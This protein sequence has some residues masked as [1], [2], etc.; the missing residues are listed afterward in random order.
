M[1][2]LIVTLGTRDL[3]IYKSIIADENFDS[4][5]ETKIVKVKSTGDEVTLNQN[6]AEEGFYMVRSARYGGGKILNNFNVFKKH[7]RYPILKPALEMLTADNNNAVQLIFIYTDQENADERFRK[8]DTIEYAYILEKLIK[9][10]FPTINVDNFLVFKEVTDLDYQFNQFESYLNRRG[11]KNKVSLIDNDNINEI[12]L[13]AQ[14]G[15][16]QINTAITL[17]LIEHFPNLKLLQKKEGEGKTIESSF[18]L[19]YRLSLD[20]NIIKEFINENNYSAARKVILPLTKVDSQLRPIKNCLTFLNNRINFQHQQNIGLLEQVQIDLSA[21]YLRNYKEK[22]PHHSFLID[23]DIDK[24]NYFNTFEI[25]SICQLFLK[26]GNFALGTLTY[27]RLVEELCKSLIYE[28]FNIDL[29]NYHERLKLTLNENRL[30]GI[31][32]YLRYLEANCSSPSI[33]NIVVSII[34]TISHVNRDSTKGLNLL[35]NHVW[36]IHENKTIDKTIINGQCPNFLSTNGDG[37]FDQIMKALNMPEENIYDSMNNELK[38]KLD[39]I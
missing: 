29:D 22:Y 18:P 38:S 23:L 5:I 34:P 37:I 20:K 35:R 14:G 19:T 1:K 31:P 12:Y 36:L 11:D 24:T 30:S 32:D 13:M 2:A 15:I 7:L 39:S 25:A 10:D 28:L 16:D 26:K 9:E 33:L 3:Q 6:I 27:I 4:N 21:E 17:K 8:N